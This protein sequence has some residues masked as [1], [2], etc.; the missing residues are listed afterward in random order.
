M[1]FN[2]NLSVALRWDLNICLC[3]SG[4]NI[5]ISC[6]GEGV[7]VPWQRLLIF[8]GFVFRYL[9]SNIFIWKFCECDSATGKYVCLFVRRLLMRFA[10]LNIFLWISLYQYTGVFSEIF[11]DNFEEVYCSSS[12]YM[13]KYYCRQYIEILKK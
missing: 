4:H 6:V 13:W 3:V 11:I 5:L 10:V 1:K 7:E 8:F 9:L 2:K 12:N